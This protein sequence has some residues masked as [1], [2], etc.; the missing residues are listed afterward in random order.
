M[1]VSETLLGVYPY[2]S[3]QPF[4]RGC[5]ALGKHQDQVP[6]SRL[7]SCWGLPYTSMMARNRINRSILLL[8]LGHRWTT[9]I[10][11]LCITAPLYSDIII[12]HYIIT[13]INQFIVQTPEKKLSAF[14]FCSVPTMVLAFAGSTERVWILERRS[15]LEI[16]D[17]E[18]AWEITGKHCTYVCRTL[19]IWYTTSA[20]FSAF[21]SMQ[22][23]TK[24]SKPFSHVFHISLPGR[25]HLQSES[26]TLISPQLWGAVFRIIRNGYNNGYNPPMVHC[27]TQWSM[28]PPAAVLKWWNHVTI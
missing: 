11:L 23:L 6:V 15:H 21:H 19:D 24:Q 17:L 1:G 4:L 25:V 22:M 26:W 2:K 8:Q 3:I 28:A 16:K 10:M 18:H 20:E 27:W 13:W 5:K 7:V 12:F 9:F 14:S